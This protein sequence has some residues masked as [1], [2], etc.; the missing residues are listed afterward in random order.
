MNTYFAAPNDKITPYSFDPKVRSPQPFSQDD[1]M[2]TFDSGNYLFMRY[3]F[4][5]ST[6]VRNTPRLS[7]HAA[8]T[9]NPEIFG[10][11]IEFGW[12]VSKDTFI[13]IAHNCPFSY[14]KLIHE[15][16]RYKSDEDKKNMLYG[17]LDYAHYSNDPDKYIA[18]R[19]LC[20]RANER[21][22]Y[23]NQTICNI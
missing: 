22:D 18:F 20:L 17:F 19:N 16:Y 21:Y 4:Q 12:A 9:G 1:L 8:Q 5:N 6:L 13:A 11:I 14:V 10:L 3:C 2:K 7:Y 23:E 15:I